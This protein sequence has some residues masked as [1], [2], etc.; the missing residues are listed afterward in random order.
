MW[1]RPMNLAP[2]PEGRWIP[3]P[4]DNLSGVHVSFAPISRF[5]ISVV[6]TIAVTTTGPAHA[7]EPLTA[8]TPMASVSVEVGPITFDGADCAPVPVTVNYVRAT[9]QRDDVDLIVSLDLRQPGSNTSYEI[10]PRVMVRTDSPGQIKD[11]LEVCPRTYSETSGDYVLTGD[12]FTYSMSDGATSKVDFASQRFSVTKNPTSIDLLK[13]TKERR[14]GLT[15]SGAATAATQTRGN[16]GADSTVTVSSRKPKGK[17]WVTIASLKTDNF[18][19]WQVDLKPQPTGAQIRV[20]L[21]GCT[22][23]TDATRVITVR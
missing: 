21:S 20:E 5:G 11:A 17:A 8:A 18:G 19:R 9:L 23:C 4:F 14:G 12:L 13:V 16:V 6:V 7:A 2:L 3:T 15:L 1:L 22:W 10:Y